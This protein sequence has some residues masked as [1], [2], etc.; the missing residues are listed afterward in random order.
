[1]Q[2]FSAGVFQLNMDGTKKL[3]TNGE[4]LNT[5]DTNDIISMARA[6]TG[7]SRQCRHCGNAQS[8]KWGPHVDAMF[9]KGEF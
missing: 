9:I 2:L 5:Y 8:S 1:M 4:P 6:W 3:N 7:L